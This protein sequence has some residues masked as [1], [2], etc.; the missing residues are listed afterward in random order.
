MTVCYVITLH[1]TKT[2]VNVKFRSQIEVDNEPIAQPVGAVKLRS[3][4]GRDSGKYL[5][6]L[7]V[8]IFF[9][10]SLGSCDIFSRWST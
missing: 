4:Q 8:Q 5:F 3:D 2:K 7:I 6:K 9:T 10:P 1:S